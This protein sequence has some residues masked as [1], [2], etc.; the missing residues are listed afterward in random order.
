MLFVVDGCGIVPF[1]DR[2]QALAVMGSIGG[3]TIP[4]Y[5]LYRIACIGRVP[6]VEAVVLKDD[7]FVGSFALAKVK[8]GFLFL[9]DNAVLDHQGIFYGV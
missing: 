6:Q 7:L 5:S 4:G 3:R 8:Q 9:F 2:G 1:I